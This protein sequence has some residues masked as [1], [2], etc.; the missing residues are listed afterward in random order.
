MR[1]TIGL[2]GRQLDNRDLAMHPFFGMR[3]AILVLDA[4]LHFENTRG[5]G[6][7]P[8]FGRSTR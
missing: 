1:T 6:N 5:D 2:T 4:T 8:P 7:E 3:L